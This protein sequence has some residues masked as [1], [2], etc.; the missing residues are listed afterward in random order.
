MFECGFKIPDSP[1]D[2]ADINENGSPSGRIDF[3]ND[4]MK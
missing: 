3:L 4:I 1:K 2:E